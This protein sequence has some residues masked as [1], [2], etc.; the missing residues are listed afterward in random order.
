[1]SR[2]FLMGLVTILALYNFQASV[3]GQNSSICG[4]GTGWVPF[5]NGFCYKIIDK[6][7]LVTHDQ[8]ADLCMD[9]GEVE[10]ESSLAMI[11][12]KKEQDFITNYV[13]SESEMHVIDGV[14]I[15]ATRIENTTEFIWDDDTD[16]FFSNWEPGYPTDNELRKCVRM[17]SELSRSRDQDQH[18]GHNRHVRAKDGEWA[19]VNC[20]GR[21]VV[22]CQ[23][24]A[25]WS[26]LFL[27]KRLLEA[28]N[29]MIP[30]GYLYTQ[31][32][33]TQHPQELWPAM[34]WVNFTQTATQTTWQRIY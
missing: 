18:D 16:V 31:L 11:K 10:E 23:K 33:G 4:A 22:L 17:S 9:E 24:L 7:Q 12:N 19:D 21:N 13:F 28:R 1:M 26:L 2:N 3:Q 30:V 6:T 27:Q 29:D 8:A 20:E 15:G 34:G 14:W 5:D 32:N 25:T